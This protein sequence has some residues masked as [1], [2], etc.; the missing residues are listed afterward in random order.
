MSAFAH[1]FENMFD[2]MRKGLVGVSSDIIGLS[3][4]SLDCLSAWL[5]DG[6]AHESQASIERELEAIK[7]TLRSGSSTTAAERAAEPAAAPAA[8]RGGADGDSDGL[9]NLYRI[10]FKP[11]RDL[12]TRGVKVRITSY[13]VCYTKLLRSARSRGCSS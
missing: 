13:N 10:R 11:S 4:R 3:L 6:E 5:D 1:G 7:A 12:L 2:D 9:T 8:G